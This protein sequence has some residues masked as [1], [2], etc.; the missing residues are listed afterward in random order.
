[1]TVNISL[2]PQQETRVRER[3]ARGEYAS[4]SEVVRSALRLLDEQDQ[5][6]DVRLQELRK[7]VQDGVRQAQ[8][9]LSQPL[10][11]TMAADIKARG[12]KRMAEE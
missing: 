3:V 8:A 4:V 10:N 5:L 2:T 6:R 11:E 1:M 7:K 9:G 12:R